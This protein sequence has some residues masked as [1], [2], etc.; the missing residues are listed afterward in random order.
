MSELNGKPV[1]PE[2]VWKIL[3]EVAEQ[4]KE[5]DRKFLTPFIF[6]VG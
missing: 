6:L 2:E 1:G 5:T 4:S 3:R